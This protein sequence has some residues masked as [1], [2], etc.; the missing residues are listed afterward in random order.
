MSHRRHLAPLRRWDTAFDQGAA[1]SVIDSGSVRITPRTDW[2]S[3]WGW[4]AIRNDRLAGQIPHF[5]VAKASRMAAP[6]ANEGLAVWSNNLDT[7]TWNAFDNQSIGASDIEFYNNSPF[8]NGTIYVA[9]TAMYPFSR[10]GRVFREWI[11][12]TR[13]TLKYAG[14]AT[15]RASAGGLTAPGLP[16][17]GLVVTN[18]SGFTKNN[19]ILTAY[20]HPSEVRGAYQLE[21]AMSW[22][23]GG[24]PEAEFLLDWFNVYVYPCLNPQGVRGGYYRSCP[25]DAS[26]DHNREWDDTGVLE[27]IDTI[28]TAMAADTGTDIEIGIDFHSNMGSDDGYLSS[29]DHTAT[30]YAAW[31]AKMQALD[32]GFGYLDQ[33]IAE[34][35]RT[36]WTGTYSAA[37]GVSCEHGGLNTKTLS[38]IKTNG[39][40]ALKA[41]TQMHADG[42]WTNGPGVGARDFNG[43]TDRID[44]SSVADLTGSALTISVWVYFDRINTNQ[45]IVNIG[46]NAGGGIELGNNGTVSSGQLTFL[47]DGSTDMIRAVAGSTVATGQWYNLIAT[48]TGGITAYTNAHIYRNGVEVSYDVGNS[49]NGSTEVSHTENWCIGGRYSDDLRNTDGKIAQVGV[50]NRVLT[51]TEIANLAAGYA[52][53]LAAASGLQFYFKGNTSSLVASPGGTGTADGTTSVTGVGNG[54]GIVYG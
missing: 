39:Q 5:L 11:K 6:A 3:E 40:N 25:Q 14:Q 24:S 53:D 22:L 51:S 26:R 54:P 34:S 36:L 47:V 20:N 1:A 32:A 2:N 28:K 45:Y 41:V 33:T 52:P 38:N 17:Y 48:W 15:R 29:D 27:C 31:L 37:L 8:P 30:L 13:V 43:T 23:L 50:W 21:G 44:W 46:K 19:M 12:D 9:H 7:D 16:F 42:R 18:A 35:L 4:F 10:I 49:Q